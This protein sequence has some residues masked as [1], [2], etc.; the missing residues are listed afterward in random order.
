[1]RIG[2]VLTHPVEEYFNPWERSLEFEH[3]LDTYCFSLRKRGHTC[4]KYVP[5]PTTKETITYEHKM[6]HIVRRVPTTTKLLQFKLFERTPYDAIGF[7][8]NLREELEKDKLDIV[9]YTM[10]Y[11]SFFVSSF[12]LPRSHRVVT[13]YTGGELPGKGKGPQAMIWKLV[14]GPAI[15]R[16]VLILVPEYAYPKNEV[17]ILKE[18]LHA[19]KE[20]VKDFQVLCVN[21]GVFHQID[22]S[23]A[24]QLVKFDSEALNILSV[25][26][27]PNPTNGGEREKN[28][29]LMVKMFSELLKL[30][31]EKVA[32]NIVG[33]GPGQDDLR[34]LVEDLKV[35]HRV[36]LIGY[37]SHSDLPIY[38]SASDLL[39]MPQPFHKLNDGLATYE[40]FSC[41]LP[42][43]G[44]KRYPTTDTEQIGGF[45]V[46][47]GIQEG[48]KTLA[49]KLQDKNYL[50]EKRL[51]GHTTAD[52]FSTEAVGRR[53]EE[54]YCTLISEEV[55]AKCQ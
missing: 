43:C 52:K 40:A 16:A 54:I 20:K 46:D 34:A 1:M 2:F 13:Q 5:S 39:F 41:K 28:P 26:R 6:G 36:N 50:N 47:M 38:Y 32:L 9:H 19:P 27:I 53:L 18:V 45:L 24:R 4:I 12:L 14:L 22:P 31:R 35:S 7:T 23:R 17:T 3:M 44:F 10:Y 21:T 29:F 55:T 51:E 42:V 15:K 25:T 30:S 8:L 11:S 48:A 37:V 33:W 49:E